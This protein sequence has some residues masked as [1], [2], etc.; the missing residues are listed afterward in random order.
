MNITFVGADP[1]NYTRNRAAQ[2]GKINHVTIHHAA[3]TSLAG[4]DATFKRPGAQASA[5]F[6]VQDATIHQYLQ[7]TDVPWSDANW[8]S[9]IST[10]SIEMVNSAT[11]GQWP[12][13]DKTFDTTAQLVADIL[14]RYGLGPAIKGKNVTWHRMYA[15]TTCPGDFMLSR[16]DTF[17]ALVNSYF[18]PS[19]AKK[20][21]MYPSNLTAAQL[22]HP[23]HNTNG[24]YTLESVAKPGLV[25]DVTGGKQAS[26]TLIQAYPA[27]GT[28]AQQFKLRQIT[29]GYTPSYLAPLEIIP[30]DESLRLEVKGNDRTAGAALQLYKAN[31][32]AAQQFAVLDHGDGT[33]TI[34]C[35]GTGTVIDLAGGGV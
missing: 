8:A 2:G 28:P 18:A 15:A 19:K 9:N 3:G 10:L 34:I 27:N 25:L 29:G 11:G 33:W 22:W 13:S 4:V 21:W 7:E 17:V 32:T 14:K 31:G 5:T 12:V 1:S 26:G 23:I 20:V 6:G 35:V 30:A 16:M 24:T